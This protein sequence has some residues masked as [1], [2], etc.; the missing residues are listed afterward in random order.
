M[1]QCSTHLSEQFIKSSGGKKTPPQKKPQK[2]YGD[3]SVK[4][5]ARLLKWHKAILSRKSETK[6]NSFHH[7]AHKGNKWAYSPTASCDWRDVFVSGERSSHESFQLPEETLMKEFCVMEEP[8]R[9][10]CCAVCCCWERLLYVQGWWNHCLWATIESSRAMSWLLG[11]SS[12]QVLNCFHQ[13]NH[14]AKRHFKFQVNFKG[15]VI[16]VHLHSSAVVN[17][18]CGEMAFIC[19]KSKSDGPDAY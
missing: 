12:R 3:I 13:V 15:T 6:S 16:L 18:Y 19:L 11:S 2:Q 9:F 7:P 8:W 14:S 10:H 5:E 17:R 4:D 1:Q